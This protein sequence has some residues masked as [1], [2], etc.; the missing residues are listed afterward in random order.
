MTKTARRIARDQRR[1]PSSGGWKDPAT[2]SSAIPFT[3]IEVNAG[4]LRLRASGPGVDVSS[5]GD[6]PPSSG[7]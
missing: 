3:S 4:R 6:S 7:A 1:I 2:A 5:F